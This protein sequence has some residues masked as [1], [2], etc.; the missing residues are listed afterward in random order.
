MRYVKYYTV[1]SG[2]GLADIGAIYKSVPILQQGRGIGSIFTGLTRFLKPFFI[3]G[4]DALKDQ[5]KTTGLNILK[6]IGN[7]SLQDILK[8]QTIATAQGLAD[9]AVNKVK[10][11]MQ[12]GS[13]KS[14]KRKKL[15]KRSHLSKERK[16]KRSKQKIKDIF[17]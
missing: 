7:K 11:K 3:N 14:I 6:D 8:E 15:A 2:Q 1:Q 9:K 10:R 4:I 13:G 17:S 12:D 16:T 5:A